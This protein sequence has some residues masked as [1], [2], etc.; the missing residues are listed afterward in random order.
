[1]NHHSQI[2]YILGW[3]VAL[4]AR[5]TGLFCVAARRVNRTMNIRSLTVADRKNNRPLDTEA[6]MQSRDREG[7]LRRADRTPKIRSLTVADRKHN[8]PLETEAPMKICSLT[9]ADRKPCRA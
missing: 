4:L 8:R 2:I 7:A 9:V 3:T 6:P 5:A 1:M